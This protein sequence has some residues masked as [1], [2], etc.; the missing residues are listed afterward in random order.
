MTDSSS[1]SA[2]LDNADGGTI[3]IFD[4]GL[5]GLT[6]VRHIAELLP[7]ADL[8]Y[9]GDRFRS[10]YG[11]RPR[12]EVQR[13]SRQITRR[14][15]DLGCGIIVI[16][17]NTASAAALHELRAEFPAVDFVGME[18]AVK[19][20]AHATESG[21]VG[22][23][24]T[25]G[26]L[27]GPLYESVVE[28]FGS[29]ASVIGEAAP[30]WVELVERGVTS[31]P[32]ARAAIER[33][34]APLIDAGADHIVLGCTHFPVLRAE[35]DGWLDGRAEVIDP[36]PAVARQTLRIAERRGVTE[37]AGTLVLELTGSIDGLEPLLA[38]VGLAIPTRVV[39]SELT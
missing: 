20:A 17:C 36:G 21:V 22:V 18:P 34:L 25:T 26:T 4:S 19:P 31:G 27:M 3:G 1:T 35:I 32:E 7:R 14:L 33:R 15:I 6:V 8:V 39:V 23:V 24:A 12:Y 28:R 38:A 37:G 5:G 16:A 13:F 2:S 29:G 10:P 30:D 9:I 11:P